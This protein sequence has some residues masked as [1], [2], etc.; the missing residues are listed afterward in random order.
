MEIA[1]P[2]VMFLL[3]QAVL[4]CVVLPIGVFGGMLLRAALKT[5]SS[6]RDRHEARL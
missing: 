6:D 2:I 1:L 3:T 5:T 4:L